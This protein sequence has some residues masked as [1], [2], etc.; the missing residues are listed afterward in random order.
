MTVTDIFQYQSQSVDTDNITHRD[1]F[2]DITFHTDKSTALHFK[3]II[4]GE[5]GSKI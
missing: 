2:T 3:K 1:K 5:S 4:P